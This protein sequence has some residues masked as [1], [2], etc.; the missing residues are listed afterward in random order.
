MSTTHSYSSVWIALLMMNLLLIF[1]L[2][3]LPQSFRFSMV[4]KVFGLGM[5]VL[6]CLVWLARLLRG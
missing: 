6:V 2:V 5:V 3:Y 4:V 1:P